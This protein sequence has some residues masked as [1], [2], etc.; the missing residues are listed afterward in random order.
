MQ[1][2]AQQPLA[3]PGD[4]HLTGFEISIQNGQTRPQVLQTV[5]VEVLEPG[6]EPSGEAAASLLEPVL[7]HQPGSLDQG[8]VRLAAE[9]AST[10]LAFRQACEPAAGQGATAQLH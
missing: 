2:L 5:E 6:A 8:Y 9:V 3:T 1:A 7:L 10:S 4:V